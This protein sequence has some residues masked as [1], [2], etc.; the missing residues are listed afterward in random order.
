MVAEAALWG[1]IGALAL[2]VGAEVA[3]AFHL[4]SKIIGLIMAFS[5]GALISSISFELVLPALE[6]T[7]ALQVA[8]GLLI[9]A[10]VFFV[11]DLLIDRLGGK[12]RK[13]SAGPEED[14]SGP[15]I[16]LGTVLDGIPESAVLGMS[17][18]TGDG[19]S[20]ALLAAIWVSNFPEALGATVGLEKSGMP[21]RNIRLMWWGIAGK[22]RQRDPCSKRVIWY[23]PD[24]GLPLRSRI[25]SMPSDPSARTTVI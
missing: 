20:M 5:V 4:S 19:V 22:C 14:S 1:L 13:S 16:V 18:A 21:R 15:G 6:T 11:G 12:G 2:V 25:D 8:L 3:F 9:G 23:A 24:P 10:L 17:L 7:G